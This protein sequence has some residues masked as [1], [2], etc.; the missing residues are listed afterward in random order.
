MQRMKLL[1]HPADVSISDL[2]FYGEP[3]PQ[4]QPEL[5]LITEAEAEAA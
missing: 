2:V 3:G 1:R 5:P 4:L